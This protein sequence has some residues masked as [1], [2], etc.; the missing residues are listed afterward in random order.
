MFFAYQRKVRAVD[1]QHFT[2]NK[3]PCWQPPA[4]TKCLGVPKG[5]T[6][7]INQAAVEIDMR[8]GRL[9]GAECAEL[10]RVRN[11]RARLRK[12]KAANG[13]LEFD[14]FVCINTVVEKIS[15]QNQGSQSSWRSAATTRRPLASACVY[16]YMCS[17]FEHTS[18]KAV[19]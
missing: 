1:N 19:N 5:K 12:Y 15:K 2:N 16:S 13:D 4:S 11:A 8:G 3:R 14:H 7:L 6:L 18:S 17:G 9:A 10:F